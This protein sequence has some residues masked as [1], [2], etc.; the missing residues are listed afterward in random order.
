MNNND[1]VV[2]SE[3][4]RR[5]VL[6]CQG[7]VR[8]IAWKLHQK[9][10]SHV[11]LDDLVSYGQVGLVQAASDFDPT[12]G[13]RFSTFAWYRVRGAMLDGLAQ[14][15]WFSRSDFESGRYDRLAHDALADQCHT[16]L[17]DDVHA[18]V[19][20]GQDGAWLKGG[21]SALAVAY[22]MS[23]DTFS[24]SREAIDT[25]ATPDLVVMRREVSQRIWEFVDSLPSDMAALVKATYVGGKTL[26]G[27][28]NDLGI[29]KGW[30]SRLHARALE[31][32]AD[33]IQAAGLHE[34]FDH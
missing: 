4:R 2:S 14:M 26:T 16:C 30:A 13:H 1:L 11:D 23:S 10:P 28:A 5:W 3:E 24:G 27:A 17:R 6:S 29:S 19:C 18:H 34:E 8:S 21:S 15:R 32:L 12:R 25:E 9:L 7:L 31:R 22:I 20:I 33:A